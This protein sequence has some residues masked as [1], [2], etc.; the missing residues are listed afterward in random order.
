MIPISE[1]RPPRHPGAILR[2]EF[3]SR[4]PRGFTQERLADVLGVSRPRLSDLLN[5]GRSVTPDTALRLGRAFGTGARFWMEAQ[6]AWDVERARRSRRRMREV[7]AI[8]RLVPAP[9]ASPHGSD[10]PVAERPRP[11]RRPAAVPVL[12]AAA[13][14]PRD[15]GPETRAAYY[16]EFLERRGLLNEADRYVLIRASIDA[17]DGRESGVAS[18]VGPP[19][20]RREGL[21]PDL[22]VI[23]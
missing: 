16:R 21:P 17:L 5:G 3:L 22:G 19:G 23:G 8:E 9:S 20:A 13:H 2:D 1:R 6:A 11:H 7:E 15:A 18:P 10:G 4:L 14:A 12:F